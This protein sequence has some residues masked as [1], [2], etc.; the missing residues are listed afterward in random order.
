MSN[1]DKIDA[2]VVARD[3]SGDAISALSHLELIYRN[4][5]EG[6]ANVQTII[7]TGSFDTIDAGLKADLVDLRDV[8][9]A[10]I[11]A[12]DN[13]PTRKELVDWRL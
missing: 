2:L 11:N 9:T 8:F 13:N 6:L 7:D 5:N 1:T 4:I 10:T 12:I 3:Q